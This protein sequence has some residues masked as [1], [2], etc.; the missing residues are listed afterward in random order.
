MS[1]ALKTDINAAKG[2]LGSI[3]VG[4]QKFTIIEKP[5]GLLLSELARTGSGDPEAFGVVSEFFEMTLGADDYRRFKK[6]V[7]A[8][9]LDNEGLMTKL[10]EIL[11]Q[12]MGRPTE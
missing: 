11:E 6:A 10:S 5:D 1:D 3:E 4:D 9:K 12:A 2:N 8:E 7:R